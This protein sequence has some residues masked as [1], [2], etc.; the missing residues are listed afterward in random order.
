[1]RKYKKKKDGESLELHAGV[2][3]CQIALR[4]VELGSKRF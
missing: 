2:D 3:A 4:L 1:M